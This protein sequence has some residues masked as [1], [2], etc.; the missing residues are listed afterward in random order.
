MEWMWR[1]WWIVW[2]KW[3]KVGSGEWGV[4]SGEGLAIPTPHSHSRSHN[5]QL[6]SISRSAVDGQYR[7]NLSSSGETGRN[8]KIDL[9]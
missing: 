8:L 1:K 9:I 5:L 7:V 3:R 4:G 2:R 6:E